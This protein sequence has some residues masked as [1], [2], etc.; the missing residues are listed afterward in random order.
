M[1]RINLFFSSLWYA[2]LLF[3]PDEFSRLRVHY[4]NRKGCK[5]HEKVSISPNVRIKGKFVMDE[6]SSIAQN[7]SISGE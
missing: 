2:F 7:C 6:G 1:R 5:I 3:L 4:Y